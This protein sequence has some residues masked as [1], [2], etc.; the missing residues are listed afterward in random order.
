MKKLVFFFAFALLATTASF[1]QGESEGGATDEGGWLIE[2]NTGFGEVGGTSFRLWATDGN[3]SWSAGAEAGY[4]VIDDLAVKAGL[5]YGDTGGDGAGSSF[6]SYKIGAKY[7]VIDVI[8]VGV[9]YSGASFKDVDE[10]PSYLGL[11]GGYAWFVANN[12]SIEPG[13]RYNISL[14]DEFYDSAFEFN[15]GFVLFL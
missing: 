14:N 12:V 5:G 15:I 9:D 10:N 6:F 13:L 7:Y 1:A 4:F 3:T 11:Q 8:P 2:I